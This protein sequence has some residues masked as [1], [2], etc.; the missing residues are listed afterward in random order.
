MGAALTYTR[1]YALFMLVGIAG[2]DDLD[3]PDLEAVPKVAAD[4][5]NGSDGLVARFIQIAG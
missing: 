2:E 5:R 1:R 4:R 3:A